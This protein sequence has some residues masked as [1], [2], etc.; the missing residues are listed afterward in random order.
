MGRRTL[1]Q[2]FATIPFGIV[3]ALLSVVSLVLAWWLT[4]GKFGINLFVVACLVFIALGAVLQ[5]RKTLA[6]LRRLD[7]VIRF[8]LYLVLWLFAA[9]LLLGEVHRKEQPLWIWSASSQE[10]ERHGLADAVFTFC[11]YSLLYS[12]PFII[13]C[14]LISWRRA[15]DN[16]AANVF[17]SAWCFFTFFLFLDSILGAI[18]EFV[19]YMPSDVWNG[20]LLVLWLAF[21]VIAGIVWWEARKERKENRKQV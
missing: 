9:L 3:F 16:P 13:P 2:L 15:V 10:L 7:K 20:W 17:A 5:P 21:T 19:R 18:D 12:G 1:F 14:S 4:G 6:S 8:L 11:L